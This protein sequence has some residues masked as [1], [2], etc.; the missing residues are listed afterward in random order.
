MPATG[1]LFGLKQN[2]WYDGRND[3]YKSTQ[4]ATTY[5]KQLSNLYNKDWF[6][7]LAAYN[8]G[9][10][11]IAKAI[12]K[13]K[14]KNLATDYWSLPLTKETTNYVPRLLAIAKIFANNKK[15]NIPLRPIPNKPYFNVVNIETQIDLGIA[16]KLA[17]TPLDVFYTLNPAYK[18]WCTDPD[19]PYHLLIHADK[20]DI[21]KDQLAQTEKKD[22]IKWI[23]HKI[24]N[25]ENL[26][27]LAKK[28]KTTVSAIRQSNR[29]ANNKIRAGKTLRI[30]Y[31][32]V[33]TT[34]AAA[35]NAN[36]HLYIVKR[37]DTFWDIARKFDV[38][39]K[40]IAYWNKLSL[41]KA[42]QPGQRLII[43]KG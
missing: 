34:A 41:K 16:A 17:Q 36:R 42:L 18:R 23:R 27:L 40:D 2:D 19:G 29:L 9:K 28:Y 1:R 13:N 6:L 5:L 15:Y 26:G 33:K 25:G 24:K 43:K 30:P 7:A 32:L 12:R 31:T 39:S 14:K 3:I 4:A 20:A 8:A 35:T 37:G 10:G 38:R 11:N 22:R 21:F